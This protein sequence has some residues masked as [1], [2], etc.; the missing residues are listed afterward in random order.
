MQHMDQLGGGRAQQ[1]VCERPLRAEF[2]D[3]RRQPDAHNRDRAEAP[4]R[5]DEAEHHAQPP[6]EE[7]Q[8]CRFRDGKVPFLSRDLGGLLRSPLGLAEAQPCVTSTAPARRVGLRTRAAPRVVTHRQRSQRKRSGRSLPREDRR[9]RW[10]GVHQ[11]AVPQFAPRRGP[12]PSRDVGPSANVGRPRLQNR[13]QRHVALGR[14][15]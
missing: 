4:S 10:G 1:Q 8:R 5:L 14:R 13:A 3:E 7:H 15:S 6:H 9:T 11:R 12:A 2:E